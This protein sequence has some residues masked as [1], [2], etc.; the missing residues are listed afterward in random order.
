MKLYHFTALKYVEQILANGLTKGEVVIGPDYIRNGINLTNDPDPA[1]HGLT[2]GQRLTARERR[3]M[4]AEAGACW[5]N[6][7]RLRIAVEIPEQGA[8]AC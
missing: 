5:P 2:D 4:R 1:D 6:K 3:F 7:R 8:P